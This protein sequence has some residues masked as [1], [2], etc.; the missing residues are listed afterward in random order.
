M[1]Y[2]DQEFAQALMRI[3]KIPDT[4]KWFEVRC[5]VDKPITVKCEYYPEKDNPD[6][7]FLVEYELE[8]KK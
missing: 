1:N 7:T 8:V 3:L 6:T 5:E 4:A 2:N